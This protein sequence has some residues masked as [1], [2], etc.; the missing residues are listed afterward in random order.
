MVLC[1]TSGCV[2]AVHRLHCRYVELRHGSFGGISVSFLQCWNMVR[3]IRRKFGIAMHNVQCRYMVICDGY[4]CCGPMQ[5]LQCRF[6][7]IRGYGDFGI[8]MCDV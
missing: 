3:D 5:C 7:V 4:V 1:G 8:Y 2:H 6:M